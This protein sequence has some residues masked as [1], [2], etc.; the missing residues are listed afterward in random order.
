MLYKIDSGQLEKYHDNYV[1]VSMFQDVWV[2]V[3]MSKG[4]VVGASCKLG[5]VFEPPMFPIYLICSILTYLCSHKEK[6]VSDDCTY[7]DLQQDSFSVMTV[8]MCLT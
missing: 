2:F 5:N 6:M 1:N 3:E 4:S 7:F 8:S